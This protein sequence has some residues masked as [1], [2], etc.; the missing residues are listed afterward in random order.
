VQTTA[1]LTHKAGVERGEAE[2][3]GLVGHPDGLRLISVPLVIA[4]WWAWLDLNLGLHPY[5]QNAGNRCARR[6]SRRSRLTVEVQVMC[7]HCVL[8]CVLTLRSDPGAPTA[9]VGSAGERS[10]DLTYVSASSAKSHNGKVSAARTA[11]SG[12]MMSVRVSGKPIS[13]Q[14]Q[15]SVSSPSTG[16]G[17][18]Q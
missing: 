16:S 17:V 4:L 18:S 9:A 8:L 1:A 12:R 2:A 15:T 5:Q 13:G 6:R 11:R 14:A 7:S 3:P 10:R